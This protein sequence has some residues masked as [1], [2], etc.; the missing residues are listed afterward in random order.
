MISFAQSDSE[1]I[2]CSLKAHLP[3][4]WSPTKK[5]TTQGRGIGCP[6]GNRGSPGKM[7]LGTHF[8]GPKLNVGFKVIG[9]G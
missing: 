3:V 8:K 9:L 1:M 7:Q 4:Y 5:A 2:K 6:L